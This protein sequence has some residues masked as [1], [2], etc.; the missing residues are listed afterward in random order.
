MIS[1][2]SNGPERHVVDQLVDMAYKT[3]QDASK[4]TFTRVQGDENADIIMSFN[5]S[6]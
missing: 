3:W 4:L 2:P 1:Y 6:E 5:R